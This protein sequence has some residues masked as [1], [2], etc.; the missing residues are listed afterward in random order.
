MKLHTKKVIVQTVSLIFQLA[1]LIVAFC[2]RL[3]PMVETPK[4]RLS[5]YCIVAI[6]IAAILLK[7]KLKMLLKLPWTL[8]FGGIG[9]VLLYLAYL[10]FENLFILFGA[11]FIGGLL[12][13]PFEIWYRSMTDTNSQI[14]TLS[15]RLGDILQD[16]K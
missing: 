2:W 9:C 13:V 8:S 3:P 11:A 4:T 16:K 12:S 10:N 6:I 14:D 7:G 1:P 5:L 15:K